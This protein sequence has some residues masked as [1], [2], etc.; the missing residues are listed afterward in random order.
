MKQG[1]LRHWL[2][3]SYPVFVYLWAITAWAIA[4]NAPKPSPEEIT[5]VGA[6]TCDRCKSPQYLTQNKEV[7]P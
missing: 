6:V 7:M 3:T 2:A 1:T 4:G 5:P